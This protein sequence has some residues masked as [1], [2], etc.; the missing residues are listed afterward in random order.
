MDPAVISRLGW[1]YLP[2]TCTLS[3]VSVATWGFYRINRETH[4]R[5]LATLREAGALAT[6]TAP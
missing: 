5:N 3:L 4:E 6:P 2:L 1:T